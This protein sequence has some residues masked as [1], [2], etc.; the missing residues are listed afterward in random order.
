VK[1]LGLSIRL[2][3]SAAKL[4]AQHQPWQF[5]MPMSKV[6]P[7]EYNIYHTVVTDFDS[8]K[9]QFRSS[10]FCKMDIPQFTFHCSWYVTKRQQF[11]FSQEHTDANR[12]TANRI[13]RWKRRSSRVLH[14]RAP[15]YVPCALQAAQR[16]SLLRYQR[17]SLTVVPHWTSSL[18]FPPVIHY[19]SQIPPKNRYLLPS[20]AHR[21]AASTRPCP[22]DS[23]PCSFPSLQ[24]S[25]PGCPTPLL[26]SLASRRYSLQL[27][28]QPP[29]L[30][31]S[32]RLRLRLRC[33]I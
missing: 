28:P 30:S 13:E 9:Q 27:Q 20:S 14:T 32:R 23:T 12:E 1:Y 16:P 21:A 19:P 24:L 18:S 33:E 3:S 25:L 2:C 26:F 15:P 17:W 5:I 4:I 8:I 11:I 31:L 7:H 10:R 6:T 22:L 29:S